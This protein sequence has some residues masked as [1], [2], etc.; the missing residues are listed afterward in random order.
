MREGHLKRGNNGC[1]SVMG[2]IIIIIFGCVF[3]WAF[4]DM[5]IDFGKEGL[6]FS[7]PSSFIASFIFIGTPIGLVC[8]I[9]RQR[10]NKNKPKDNQMFSTPDNIFFQTRNG[11]IC[12]NNPYRGFLVVGA[13][14]SGKSESIAVPLL[15]QFIGKGFSGIAYDFKFPALAND[16]Q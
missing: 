16:I 5:I 9:I 14:G 6:L 10:Q 13:A 11:T 8:F 1:L 4:F 15:S 12:L 7:S 3:C 2:W